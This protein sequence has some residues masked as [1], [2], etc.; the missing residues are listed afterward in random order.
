MIDTIE[1]FLRY[2]CGGIS[3][4]CKST[5]IDKCENHQDKCTCGCLKKDDTQTKEQYIKNKSLKE[6][7]PKSP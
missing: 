2:I 7:P 6:I 1:R 5:C 3:C 4:S